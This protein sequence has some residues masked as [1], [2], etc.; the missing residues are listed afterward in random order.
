M[1]YTGCQS[2]RLGSTWVMS[3]SKPDLSGLVKYKKSAALRL[4]EARKY[5][6]EKANGYE[7]LLFKA[8]PTR[9]KNGWL[10]TFAGLATR[11]K[12]IAAFCYA[13]VNHESVQENVG[14]CKKDT[15]PLWHYRPL[16]KKKST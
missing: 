1:I 16:Q 7:R 3:E 10:L 14:G 13:C 15:C 9:Y 12:A 11:K 4:A 2:K 6:E 8:I 5:F